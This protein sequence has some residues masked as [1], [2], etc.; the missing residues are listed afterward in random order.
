M[1]LLM[2]TLEFVNAK[3][4]FIMHALVFTKPYVYPEGEIPHLQYV[5]SYNQPMGATFDTGK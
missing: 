4:L 3:V 2:I 5:I 1:I